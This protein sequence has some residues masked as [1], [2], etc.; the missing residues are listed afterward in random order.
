M[1][2]RNLDAM[3]KPRSVALI[4]ASQN[5]KSVGGVLAKN[6]MQC[7]FTG[8]IFPVNSRYTEIENA[9]ATRIYSA[10]HTLRISRL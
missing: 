9:L 10:F 7:G 8:D 3:F 5:P 1:T 6:L 4:G 2:V